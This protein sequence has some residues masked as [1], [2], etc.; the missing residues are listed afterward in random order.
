MDGT[1][2]E[3]LRPVEDCSRQQ[4]QFGPMASLVVVMGRSRSLA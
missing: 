2:D 1:C 3:L 4:R